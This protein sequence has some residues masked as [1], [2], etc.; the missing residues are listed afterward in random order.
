LAWEKLE[1]KYDPVSALSLVKTER[2]FR[3]SK[4]GKGE[5]PETWATNLEDL[6]L[7]LDK[8]IS[9]EIMIAK[10]VGKLRCGILQKNG[11]KLI[12][13]LE[14]VKFVPELWINLFSIGKALKNGFNLS[15]DGEIIKLSEGN[16]TLIFDKVVRTKNGFAP[17]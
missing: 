8:T 4:L 1:K 6:R 2:L 14:S 10:K 17:C 7:K 16:V 5:D 9:E 12:I 11:E 15:N 3:E 13:K